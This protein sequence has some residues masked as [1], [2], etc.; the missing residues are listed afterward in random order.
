MYRNSPFSVYLA[1]L[2]LLPALYASSAAAMTKYIAFGDSIT[3]GLG[4]DNCPAEEAQTCGYITRLR[5]RF[6]AA[7]IP[8]TFYNA[9]VGG[10]R[11]PQALERIDLVLDEQG[12]DVF[13][14][15]EGTNDI[16]RRISPETTLTNL[17][18]LAERAEQRG[19]T[20]VHAT[21]IL[22][23][24]NAK[25]DA[26]NLLN[27][28]LARS[29]RELAFT[30]GRDLIDPFEIF[31]QFP[32]ETVYDD[33]Y[34]SSTT[35]PVGHPNPAGY[36]LL[37]GVFS[38]ALLGIDTVPPVIGDLLPV[39]GGGIG[40]LTPVAVRLHDFGVGLDRS[41]TRMWINE[42]EVSFTDAGSESWQEITYRA[43]LDPGE[44][45]ARV[46]AVDLLGNFTARTTGSFTVF[47]VPGPCEPDEFTLCIDNQV[48]DRRFQVTLDWETAIGGGQEGQG[49]ALPLASIGL[50]RGGLFSFFEVNNPEMLI[51]VLNG[52]GIN[53][54]FWIFGAPTTTLG[55][56][57]VVTDTLAA[58]FGMP[59]SIYEWR[60]SNPD[61][62]NADAFAD[63][64]AFPTCAFQ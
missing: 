47:E 12:G 35:D 59:R 48:G 23:Y 1:L 63:T 57:L 44:Y 15:M 18:L 22:R 54:N 26:E 6:S 62:Q 46:T 13:L 30:T 38:D 8:A 52:C 60:Q 36:D 49:K 56:D 39:D 29:I 43:G 37:G 64:L 31:S 28:N 58:A 32:E 20:A 3:L 9:G 10:E 61:G 51:K 27:R 24:P 21:L 11:T 50:R 16:T 7:N 2:A 14:L 42:S 25:V 33:F 53:G 40:P 19:L 55:F 4:F 41:E 17:D 45:T 5:Q 34:F